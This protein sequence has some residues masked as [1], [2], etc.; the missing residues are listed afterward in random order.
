MSYP[1][2]VPHQVCRLYSSN[3]LPITRVGRFGKSVKEPRRVSP[4]IVQDE[5]GNELYR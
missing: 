3:N 5:Y 4:T 2:N 1:G